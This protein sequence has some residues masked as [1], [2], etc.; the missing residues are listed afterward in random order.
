MAMVSP[1]ARVI[2]PFT[3]DSRTGG[4]KA[5]TTVASRTP[6]PGFAWYSPDCPPH[7]T[8]RSGLRGDPG[9]AGFVGTSGAGETGSRLRRV[10]SK[11]ATGQ[12]LSRSRPG[13]TGD[14]WRSV[15]W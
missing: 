2:G 10:T 3:N 7:A 5:N 11:Y 13:I 9:E 6:S 8:P 1:C 12:E 4:S 14:H 15:A